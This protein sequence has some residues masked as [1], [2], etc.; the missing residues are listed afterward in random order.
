MP[1]ILPDWVPVAVAAAICVLTWLRGDRETQFA[2]T[3]ALVTLAL[4]MAAPRAIRNNG[5]AQTVW[6]LLDVIVYGTLAARS[7][8]WWT[9]AMASAALVDLVTTTA[10]IW[11]SFSH[12]AIGTAQLVWLGAYEVTLIVAACTTR[13]VGKDDGGRVATVSLGH[14][15]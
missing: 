11:S 4:C 8:R 3:Y 9:V 14:L 1:Y 5:Y 7:A 15:S 10:W 2:S 6:Q 12:W 13:R